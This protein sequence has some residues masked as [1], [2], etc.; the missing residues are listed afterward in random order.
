MRSSILLVAT[1]VV[2]IATTGCEP[3]ART[4]KKSEITTQGP[5]GMT[6]T[7][8]D[9]N[10]ETSPGTETRITTKK[11]KPSQIGSQS[12]NRSRENR[13]LHIQDSNIDDSTRVVFDLR[14]Q[15]KYN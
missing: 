2:G 12:V 8:I 5:Q 7:T 10:V 4:E 13:P 6:T 11:P 3:K 9:K 14:F 15:R 1:L